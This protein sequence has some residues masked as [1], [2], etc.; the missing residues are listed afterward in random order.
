MKQRTSTLDLHS[1]YLK[2]RSVGL[3]KMSTSVR[4]PTKEIF[5][6]RE[7]PLHAQ[8]PQLS[9]TLAPAFHLK[10]TS[11]IF[12][13]P[14]TLVPIQS[15]RCP[16]M[17]YVTW[18]WGHRADPEQIRDTF[19]RGPPPRHRLQPM[20]LQFQGLLQFPFLHRCKHLK[21]SVA[22]MLRQPPRFP[23]TSHTFSFLSG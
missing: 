11:C 17:F 20:C 22:R 19:P 8:S 15:H 9:P 10:R 5:C 4:S 3:C 2:P 1:G 13:Y 14:F 21:Y 7:R 6:I 12:V 18:C 16:T 23:H